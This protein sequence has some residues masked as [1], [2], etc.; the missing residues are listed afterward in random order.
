MRLDSVR[1][2]KQA[3]L[4][5]VV[6]PLARP[7]RMR[8]FSVPAMPVD[9]LPKVARTVALGIS[10]GKREND[11]RLAVRVQRA[12]DVAAEIERIKQ[13]ARGEVEVRYVGRITKR[14][15]RA[16]ARQ[17]RCGPEGFQQRDRP[18]R[19]GQSIGHVEVTAGTLGAFV[20]KRR[21]R[22]ALVLSNN[23]VIA[24]ENNASAGDPI[25]QPGTIDD[26]RVARDVIGTLLEFVRMKPTGRN[27]VDCA[28]A[29]L[30]EAMEF[31]EK[32]LCGLPALAGEAEAEPE[33]L[34][35]KVGRTTGLTRG[36]VT[37]I[38]VDNVV[39]NYDFGNAR[40]DNQIEIESTGRDMFSDGGDSG[41][42]I[43]TKD[44]RTSLAVGLLFAGSEQG[45]QN[46]L[47]LTYANPI[48]AVFQALKIRLL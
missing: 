44:E 36:R 4:G 16:R 32:K 1:G 42:L 28:I 2:L 29:K 48:Q 22:T 26:G 40:F 12:E 21:G 8:A 20:A 39:V 6:R 9:R 45:G 7:R 38:E 41:S 15:K 35:A 17:R 5:E 18:L 23:H 46:D 30:D 25:I 31:D 13:R 14:A 24:N 19:I 37:A 34:V 33:L 47:G 43:V 27:L 3:L 10:R 11:F